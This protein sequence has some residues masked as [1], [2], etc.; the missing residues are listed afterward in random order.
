ML[1]FL[2]AIN[3]LNGLMNRRRKVKNS[4]PGG[5]VEKKPTWEEY[6]KTKGFHY[7]QLKNRWED[8]KKPPTFYD[9]G[10]IDLTGEAAPSAELRKFLERFTSRLL[11]L[12][13]TGG[14]DSGVAILIGG[15]TLLFA[16]LRVMPH[17]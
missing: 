15:L 8:D 10:P 12:P 3:Q 11:G 13:K 7:N 9:M 5:I 6:M 14:D 4:T 1:L 16:F 17:G 2:S